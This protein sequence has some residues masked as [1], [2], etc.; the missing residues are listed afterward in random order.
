LTFQH[1]EDVALMHVIW[2]NE[3]LLLRQKLQVKLFCEEI[4]G[5][6]IISSFFYRL[7]PSMI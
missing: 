3:I 2:E 7:L 5:L 6:M 1:I 4:F